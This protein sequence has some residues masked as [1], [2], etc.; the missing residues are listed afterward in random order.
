MKGRY[1]PYVTD[2]QVN[3]TL[4]RDNDPAAVTLEEAVALLAARSAK[5]PAKPKKGR[6]K[7]AAAK[8]APAGVEKKKAP[9]GAV[10]KAP[11]KKRA[12]GGKAQRKSDVDVS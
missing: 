2:G 8:K 3:A 6:G 12:A 7:P 1:G 10:K 11:A 4:P 9:S 5:G